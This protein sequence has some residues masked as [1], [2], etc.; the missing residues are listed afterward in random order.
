MT[1]YADE[2]KAPV[3]VTLTEPGEDVELKAMSWIWS[4]L[5]HLNPT[6]R[7]RVVQWIT[8]RSVA[9]ETELAQ[10]RAVR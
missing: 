8:A 10:G 9:A 2:N 1:L 5:A 4:V 3:T 7:G 6:Q